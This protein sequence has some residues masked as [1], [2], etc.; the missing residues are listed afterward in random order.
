[1]KNINV[2]II[3]LGQRGFANLKTVMLIDNV[4]I[5]ALCDTYEIAD[6]EKSDTILKYVF[7]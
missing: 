6:R 2:G 1:M 4:N 5:V 3:G 7:K